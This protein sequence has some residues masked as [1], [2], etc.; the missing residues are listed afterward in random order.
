MIALKMIKPCLNFSWGKYQWSSLKKYFSYGY[1]MIGLM[2]TMYILN[3]SDRF[4]IKGFYSTR[5]LGIYAP[6]YAIA[7]A[8][9]VLL[10]YG[11][12]RGYYPRVL[13][14]WKDRNHKK[15][16]LYMKQAL[17]NYIVLITPAVVGVYIVSNTL[18]KV[19]LD[20]A[21]IEGYPVIGLVA[22]GMGFLGLADYYNKTWELASNTGQIF[23]NSFIAAI[24]NL[25]LNF[26]FIPKYGYIAAAY[27]TMISF[28]FYAILSYVRREHTFHFSPNISFLLKVLV[29]NVVMAF[30]VIM[31]S[32]LDL[33][34]LPLMLL[35]ACIG[36]L[37]YGSIIWTLK[38]YKFGGNTYE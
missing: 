19:V 1:P 14:V 32:R 2:L 29:A 23:I 13:K 30:C 12:S 26:I 7:S 6:N 35:Q 3:V 17:T 28:V 24:V 21:Y 36:V 11:L 22:I 9:F 5:E 34:L 38:V 16:E 25:V 8:L 4:M 31:T 27:T 20:T 10:T 18:A 15:T 33:N 37:T